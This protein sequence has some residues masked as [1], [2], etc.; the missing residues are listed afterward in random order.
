[1]RRRQEYPAFDYVKLLFVRHP[2]SR[3]VEH[4]G[5]S[6]FISH[7]IVVFL[8]IEVVSDDISVQSNV[9]S[10]V[11]MFADIREDRWRVSDSRLTIGTWTSVTLNYA[12]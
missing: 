9:W 7:R 11:D 1:M 12:A 5:W 8:Q 2:S 10:I 3:I 4:S 6:G